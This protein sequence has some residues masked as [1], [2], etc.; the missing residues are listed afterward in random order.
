MGPGGSRAG[1]TC[2]SCGCSGCR[3]R[4]TWSATGGGI[5]HAGSVFGPATLDDLGTVD[6][7][8]LDGRPA[9]QVLVVDRDDRAPSDALLV[10]LRSLGAATDHAVVPGSAVAL[11]RPTEYSDVPD[12]V[13][14]TVSDW[15]GR[16]AP[17]H[18]AGRIP[19]RT[20]T[21]AGSVR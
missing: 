5:A 8:A 13:V 10:R 4:T 2:A 16:S 15:V 12:V 1:P 3:S 6:V 19:G 14:Q 9:P 7:T 21:A 18:G 17:G 11:D 20:T